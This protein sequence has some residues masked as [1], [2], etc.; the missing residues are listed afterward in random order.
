MSTQN[1][2]VS[3]VFRILEETFSP[4]ST[5]RLL[6][7]IQVDLVGRCFPKCEVRIQWETISSLL[8]PSKN[9]FYLTISNKSPGAL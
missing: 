3:V 8:S 5:N 6:P 1:I 7:R 2:K 4:V 9:N